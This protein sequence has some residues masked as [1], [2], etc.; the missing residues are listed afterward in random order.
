MLGELLEFSVAADARAESVEAYTALGL[1]ELPV[2]DVVAAPYAALTDGR[3]SL[4]LHDRG[5]DGPTPTFV[6]PDLARHVAA[7]ET[8][9]VE[10]DFLELG[11]E[12]FHRAGFTAPNGIGVVLLEARTFA[13]APPGQAP[14]V[15]ACG[16]FAELSIA[17]GSLEASAEFWTALGFVRADPLPGTPHQCVRLH[18]AGLALGLHETARFR[19]ALTFRAASLAARAEY[20]RAKGFELRAGTPLTP[21]AAS[22]ATLHPPGGVPFFLV[23]AEDAQHEPDAE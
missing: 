11:D 21:D 3:I 20:L 8:L 4:G 15:P 14:A 7:L 10:F 17:T 23:G 1:A 5:V 18:G 9:G 22:S 13:P 6:R 16:E 2:A 19:S 12:Q